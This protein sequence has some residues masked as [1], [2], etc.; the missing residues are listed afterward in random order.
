[1]NDAKVS[2]KHCNFLMNTGAA[3]AKDLEDLGNLV[4]QKV[5]DQTGVLLEWEIIRLGNFIDDAC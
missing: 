4:Q 2:E 3:T 1:M 5:L